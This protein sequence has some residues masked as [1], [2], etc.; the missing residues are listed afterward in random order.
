MADKK[1]F[2]WLKLPSGFFGQKEIKR[3]RSIA[4][5]DTYT[6]IYLKMLLRSLD[7][8]GR[9]YFE[10]FGDDFADEL[11][12][13]IDEDRDNVRMTIQYLQRSKLLMPGDDGSYLLVAVKDMTGSET[14]SARRMR[15]HRQAKEISDQRSLEASHCDTHVTTSD[16]AVTKCDTE[17]DKEIEPEREKEI[18]REPERDTPK[19]PK[20]RDASP[21]IARIVDALNAR[22]GTHYKAS[23]EVTRRHINARLAEGYTVEDFETVISKKCQEWMGTEMEKFLR[24]ETLFGTKFE[25]YLNARIR[26]SRREYSEFDEVLGFGR[27]HQDAYEVV[28]EEVM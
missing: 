23:S 19:A 26:P 18:E 21:D 4:G 16:T 22:A 3:L 5:G 28:P 20:G 15:K 14:D 12:M 17:I 8:D 11:A 10:G 6:V 27:Q 24:P 25:S 13:D 2:F 7:D 9:L 1:R